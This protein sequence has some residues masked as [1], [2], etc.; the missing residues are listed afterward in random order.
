MKPI[1]DWIQSVGLAW[2]QFWFTP[3]DGNVLGLI[4]LLTGLTVC[5]THLAWT[6]LLQ[7]FLGPEGMLPQTYRA[8]FFDSAFAWSHFD[9]FATPGPLWGIHFV[10]LMVM[11]MFAFGFWTRSTGIAT[12]FFVISYANRATGATFG[13]DQIAGFLV[14][15]LAIANG[16]G[17]F[18]LAARLG[19]GHAKPTTSIANNI[20]TRLIQIHLCA[21]YL[22]AG[23]G[24]C[25]GDYWWNGE[26]IWGA[27]A[28]YEYQTI[29][30]TWLAAHMW[31]INALTLLTL[32]FEVGYAALIWQRLTRPVMLLL[33]IP[34]H[35][36]IGLCMGMLEFGLIMLI[37][38]LAFVRTSKPRE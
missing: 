13:L 17:A 29:D 15:Y 3:R 31:L 37:A 21:V 2:N 7:R 34:L 30:M 24:K 9:W 8:Q 22:F 36:G 32:L 38:N 1:L 18:S 27:V 25:Q 10:A 4:R 26:A 28:S 33:A 5:Y 35:L 6:P 20:A 19:F 12:A 11:L 23:L 14:L 16:S